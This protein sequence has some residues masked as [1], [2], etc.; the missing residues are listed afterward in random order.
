MRVESMVAQQ[1][2]LAAANRAN[3]RGGRAERAADRA[4][5]QA[6]AQ[7]AGTHLPS[8][9][10]DRLADF[11]ANDPGFA[12]AVSAQLPAARQASAR[13]LAAYGRGDHPRQSPRLIDVAG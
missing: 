7:A 2:V 3:G 4:V 10:A 6:P 11:F 5:E 1:A 9:V 12:A 13:D 8:E